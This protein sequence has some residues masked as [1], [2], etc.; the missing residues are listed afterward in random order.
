MNE[1]KRNECMLHPFVGLPRQHFKTI[2]ADPPWKYKRPTGDWSG[3][4]RKAVGLPYPSMTLDGIKALP[5]GRLAADGC[6]LWLWTTNAFLRQGFDVL[7]A[8]G[9][10][11]LAPVHWIKPSGMGNWFVNRTQTILFG[12]RKPCRMGEGR[13]SPNII[14]SSLPRRHSE[15]PE[16]AF[17][18][19]ESVSDGPRLELFARRVRP[20]WTCWG[21]EVEA[22]NLLSSKST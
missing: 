21:N 17:T 14:T 1:A 13:Y 16:E 18:L 7:D 2:V 8:W 11:Y 5:V 22:N 4:G 9:F 6:H 10:K 20:G 15:K 19:I 3:R 12:Y